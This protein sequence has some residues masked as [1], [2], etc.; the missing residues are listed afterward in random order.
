[1]TKQE[2]LDVS[3]QLDNYL[4]D[5]L[6]KLIGLICISRTKRSTC[7]ICG[8]CYG[9][10]PASACLRDCKSETRTD[11]LTTTT[12]RYHLE[13]NNLT[14]QKIKAKIDNKGYH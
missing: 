11:S 12:P 2:I 7:R 13:L 3:C 5:L 8:D 4:T 6:T 14:K 9:A 1:M 10:E